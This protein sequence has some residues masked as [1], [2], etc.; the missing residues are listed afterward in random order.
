MSESK[1][2]LN[3]QLQALFSSPL[4]QLWAALIIGGL[5]I[6]AVLWLPFRREVIPSHGAMAMLSPPSQLVM[7]GQQV[8]QEEGCQYCHSQALR[9]VA[10]EAMR[11]ANAGAYG[12]FLAPD[13]MEYYFEAPAMRG[14][15][16]LGPDLSRLAGRL[17]EAQLR[18]LLQ[19]KKS[20][21]PREVFHRFSHLFA[22]DAG[23]SPLMLSWRAR[24]MMNAGAQLSDPH[25]RSAFWL[26]EDQSRGD[27]LVAYL[28]SLGQKQRESAGRFYA[29]N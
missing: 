8:Y 24:M 10:W 12:Y 23:L 17:D 14:S 26:L 9:P 16:R 22:S 29:S 2:D 6:T 15:A 3:S 28:L 4:R 20:D 13:A 18:A 7:A 1:G 25:Q 5:A 21:S 19:S 27:V 11:M